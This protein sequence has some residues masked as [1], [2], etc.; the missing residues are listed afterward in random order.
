M[1]GNWWNFDF[2]GMPSPKQAQLSCIEA[3]GAGGGVGGK[4]LTALRK[5]GKKKVDKKSY[6]CLTFT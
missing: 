1:N 5:L 3:T 4:K 2:Q 6:T